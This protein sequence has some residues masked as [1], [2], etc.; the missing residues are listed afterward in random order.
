MKAILALLIESAC[1]VG[2]LYYYIQNRSKEKAKKQAQ[3]QRRTAQENDDGE[4]S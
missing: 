2:I 4:Q 1:F 3:E